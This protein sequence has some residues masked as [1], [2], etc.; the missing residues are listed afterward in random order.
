MKLA[1]F[2]AVI[3]VSSACMNFSGLNSDDLDQDMIKSMLKMAMPAIVV[4]DNLR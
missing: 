4:P 3:T 1:T 2:F